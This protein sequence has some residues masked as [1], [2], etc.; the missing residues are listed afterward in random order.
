MSKGMH[1]VAARVGAAS[2]ILCITH[3]N[4]DGDAL[5]SALGLVFAARGAGKKARAVFQAPLPGRFGFL[6]DGPAE[7]LSPEALAAEAGR[8]DCVVVVDTCSRQQ[9]DVFAKPLDQARQN[10]V[11]IDHHNTAD[12][13]GSARWMDSSAG[14]AGLMVMEMVESLGWPLE[15]R[16]VTALATAIETDTGWLRFPR[17]DGRCIRAMAR[18]VDLGAEPSVLFRLLEQSDRFERLRLTERLLHSLEMHVGGRVAVMTLRE[19]DFAQTGADR[20]ETENLINEAM[21]IATVQAAVLLVEN[22]AVTRVSFRSRDG[23]DVARIAA[24][25]GGGGHERAAGA[26]L[27]LPINEARQRV[28]AAVTTEVQH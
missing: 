17:T 18:L 1:A 4:P 2:S 10:V 23:V 25:L 7:V 15:A 3:V 14:A 6:L 26:K 12:D 13:I 16:A 21:R 5:G 27:A 28:L 9:L 8:T 22:G 19:E 24:N 11:V 20:S